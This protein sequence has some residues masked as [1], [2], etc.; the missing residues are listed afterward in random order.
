M[1]CNRSK[2]GYRMSACNTGFKCVFSNNSVF[3]TCTFNDNI[4][5]YIY[6]IYYTNIF[7]FINLTTNDAMLDL[8]SD[9]LK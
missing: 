4:Y 6:I 2:V 9:I 7:S 3:A 5:I 1:V 8:F